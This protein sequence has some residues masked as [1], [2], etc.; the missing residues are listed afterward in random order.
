[1]EGS[2]P[3]SRPRKVT[4]DY[5]HWQQRDTAGD[6]IFVVFGHLPKKTQPKNPDFGSPAAQSDVWVFYLFTNAI[7]EWEF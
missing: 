1:M 3:A 7:V 5:L 6:P 4:I 2:G